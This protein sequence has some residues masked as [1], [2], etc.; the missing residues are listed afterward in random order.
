MF[1]NY[2][3]ACLIIPSTIP[4]CDNPTISVRLLDNITW[5]NMNVTSLSKN[6]NRKDGK[7]MQTTSH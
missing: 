1:L 4:D 7:A 5:Y 2:S 6:M 3:C